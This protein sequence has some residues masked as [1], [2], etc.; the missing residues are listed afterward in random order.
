MKKIIVRM[1]ALVAGV[2]L[3]WGASETTSCAASTVGCKH[4]VVSKYT[5]YER[6]YKATDSFCPYTTHTVLE[7]HALTYLGCKYCDYV[8]LVGS[9]D[10]IIKEMIIDTKSVPFHE[11]FRDCGMYHQVIAPNTCLGVRG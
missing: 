3:M 8:I 1:T 10:V 11:L 9:K 5:T 2:M 7:R 4:S 6:T